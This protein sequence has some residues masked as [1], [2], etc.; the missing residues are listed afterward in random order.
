VTAADDETP[1]PPLTAAPAE[2]PTEAADQRLA[3][4]LRASSV[5]DLRAALHRDT[6]PVGDD[7]RGR[8]DA[9]DLM[10]EIVGGADSTATPA[11]IGPYAIKGV[12]GRGGMGT[13]YLGWQEELEREVAVKVLAPAY[14]GDPTMQKR[15]R[16]EARATAALH[17]RHIVPI[18]D[19]GE[20]QGVL[21]FAME[22]VVGVSLDKHIAAARR[23]GKKPLAPLDAARRFAGVADA[24]GLAHRRR[25]LHRDVKPGNLLVGSDGT[26]ALT[27]FGL[28]KALDHATMR[29][30]S[31]DA[32]FL[33]TLHYSSP[34]QAL[35]RDLGPPSDLYSLGVTIFEA[36][37]G[38]LPLAARTTEA[39]LHEILYGTPRR[40]RDFVPSPPRDLEAVLDKLLAREPA[41]R[42]QDGEAL[43]RD[44]QRIADGEPVHI[45]RL[46]LHVRAWRRMRKN[47]VL[48]GA[49]AASVVLTLLTAV[50]LG[51][52][53]KERVQG[54]ALRHQEELVEIGKLVRDERGDVAGPAGLLAALTGIDLPTSPPSPRVLAALDRAAAA[55]PDDELVDAMRVAWRDD[56]APTA[57]AL[58]R[59]GRGYEA[60]RALDES[61]AAALV[62][63]AG[64]ELVVELRLYQIYL[65][66]GVARLTAAVARPDD[67]RTDLV[68]AGY[69]RPGAAFPQSLLAALD[70]ATAADPSARLARVVDELASAAPERRRVVAALLWAISGLQPCPRANLMD[71]GLDHPQRRALRAQALTWLGAPP[72]DALATPQPTGLAASLAQLCAEPLTRLGD[73]EFV[74]QRA[75][76]AAAAVAAA[77]APESQLYSWRA[78]LAM[79]T[80]PPQRGSVA[81]ADDR[82]P[83]QRLAAFDRLL[84]LTPPRALVALWLP[85][86]EALRRDYPNLR[87]M[88]RIAAMMHVAAGSPDAL[89]H[90]GAWVAAA[91]GDPDARLF[92]MR[93][94]LLGGDVAKARDDAIVVVQ[95]AIEPGPA[96]DAVVK[97]CRETE[98]GLPG[99]VAESVRLLAQQFEDARAEL[100]AGGRTR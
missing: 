71:F 98:R 79:M 16:A 90:A 3:D 100:A 40:L 87:G 42:Y 6:T 86:F 33:G 34:E 58:L 29:L 9:L 26:L 2:E 1:P 38:E 5:G 69:L 54:L 17:H 45:R 85:P 72:A 61:V 74:R 27:D 76:R 66:R 24:L 14:S 63:R 37:T 36:V 52:L 44:L 99:G 67:A 11:R 59:E 31:K 93:A 62:E 35:G 20:A 25:L 82:E 15:F 32:G 47:P 48:S 4:A 30:T 94:S 23:F 96:I 73:P 19:Y 41:D 80:Q 13:V 12:L 56:P 8:L 77:V 43:A 68:L 97:V 91:D 92:R 89:R 21:F 46:P 60:A 10:R 64:R 7:L 95:D 84:Q 83:E 18:Y 55:D 49:I 78:A 50:L 65:A 81:R 53:R 88:A 28:A 70:V 39:M 75:D 22:R 57:T 51:V